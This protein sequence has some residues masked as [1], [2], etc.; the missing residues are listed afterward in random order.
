M[1]SDRLGVASVAA[2]VTGTLSLT[3]DLVTLAWLTGSPSGVSAFLELILTVANLAGFAFGAIASL[4]DRSGPG[5][6]G[7]HLSWSPLVVGFLLLAAY[8]PE[9]AA[10]LVRRLI[11]LVGVIFNGLADVLVRLA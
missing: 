9:T 3:A 2:S 10:A 5:T 6:V 1:P 4:R 7:L 11:A 8:Q